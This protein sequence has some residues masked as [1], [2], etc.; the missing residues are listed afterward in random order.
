M[1][2]VNFSVPEGVKKAF[3]KAFAK[4]NK[5]GV[6]ADLMREAVE[7]QER[8]KIRREALRRIAARGHARRAVDGRTLRRAREMGRP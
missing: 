4:Q 2:T 3:N 1:A 5:S 6:M 8:L 7:R